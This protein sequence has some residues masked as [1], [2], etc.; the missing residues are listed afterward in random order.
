MI[1][2]EI[3]K[4]V[5]Y[6]AI[7]QSR[8]A[9]AAGPITG[10]RPADGQVLAVLR[11]V[12]GYDGGTKSF[13]KVLNHTKVADLGYPA[14]RFPYQRG[15]HGLTASTKKL[16]EER[17]GPVPPELFSYRGPASSSNDLATAGEW[18][19]SSVT[20]AIPG[21]GQQQWTFDTRTDSWARVSGGPPI[22]VANLIIQM[23]RYKTIFLSRKL[24]RTEPSA[25]VFGKGSAEVFSGIAGTTAHG[26]GG[27][28]AKGTWSK[29]GLLEVT[30]YV[31]SKDFPMELQPGT[32]WIILAPPGTRI[33][34]RQ[35]RP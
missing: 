25:R 3:T 6:I 1:F 35:A 5:R 17:R 2:E 20:V 32:T 21:H 16:R 8:Q 9:A 19:P 11:P 18:R 28:A 14:H 13:I 29:S 27:L 22:H 24:G 23:V 10:T 34:T 30:T 12:I 15:A 7:F 4:P 26:P 33:S 31:D